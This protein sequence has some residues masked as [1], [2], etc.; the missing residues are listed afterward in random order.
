MLIINRL[1]IERKNSNIDTAKQ[2][3]WT[4]RSGPCEGKGGRSRE[5]ENEK[6]NIER[7]MRGRMGER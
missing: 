6:I 4:R 5:K 2:G 3:N 1:T 7:G